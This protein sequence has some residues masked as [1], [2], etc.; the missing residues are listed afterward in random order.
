M[1]RS[2]LSKTKTAKSWK[3][4]NGN[5]IILIKLKEKKSLLG[6]CLGVINTKTTK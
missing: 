6:D 4:N 5:R 2:N 1:L 3:S